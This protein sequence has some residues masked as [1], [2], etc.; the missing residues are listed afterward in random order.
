ML[1]VVAPERV[2]GGRT[3]RLMHSDHEVDPEVSES[4]S[5]SSVGMR[6]ASNNDLGHIS[7]RKLLEKR[8]RP[9]MEPDAASRTGTTDSP[10]PTKVDDER[11]SDQASGTSGTTSTQS[12]TPVHHFSHSR[13]AFLFRSLAKGSPTPTPGTP[14][15]GHN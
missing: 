3:S 15:P 14:S 5:S 10:P 12:P 4:S 6:L 11:A 7:V 1:L 9:A 13:F 2:L 8:R